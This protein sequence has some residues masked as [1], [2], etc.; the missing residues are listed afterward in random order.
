MREYLKSSSNRWKDLTGS[1]FN[2]LKVL[3]YLG[4]GTW[5]CKCDCGNYIEAKTSRIKTG[6]TRSCG[7]IKKDNAK[8]HGLSYSKEYA[9]WSSMKSRCQNENNPS[10]C[11]YGGRGISV[12]KEWSESFSVFHKDMG[13]CP[14][15]YSLERKDNNKGYNKNNCKWASSKDQALNRRSSL[16]INYRGES[17]PL[18]TWCEE[19]K[20]NYGKVYMRLTKLKWSVERAL[21]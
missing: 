11:R 21:S 12:S 10:Y 9:S 7:H 8:K 13:E 14:N 2:F 17:K 6:H 15:G 1:K 3:G 19:L 4:D 5:H 18:K 20:L 16:I